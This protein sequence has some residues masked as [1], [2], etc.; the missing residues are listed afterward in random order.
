MN[1]TRHGQGH[2]SYVPNEVVYEGEWSEDLPHGF[3][4]LTM[5]DRGRYS[6]QWSNGSFHGEGTMVWGA[7][8]LIDAKTEQDPEESDAK[9]D[10]SERLREMTK[11]GGI[12]VD[13]YEGGWVGGFRF[14]VV[15][16]SHKS[17]SAV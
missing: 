15:P 8:T 7:V 13:C 1:L 14:V 12:G 9:Q 6:G 2:M 10:G 17:V 11:S 4:T 5:V 3:G 16:L